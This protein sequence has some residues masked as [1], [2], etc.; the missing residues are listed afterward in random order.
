MA[1]A[2]MLVEAGIKV[3]SWLLGL[4]EESPME[5]HSGISSEYLLPYRL[6]NAER[7]GV[8][9]FSKVIATK[10]R[11]PRNGGRG[12]VKAR[13]IGRQRRTEEYPITAATGIVSEGRNWQYIRN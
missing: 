1:S 6:Q 2:H 3:S 10:G 5:A 8:K 4:R 12:D 11:L 13:S 9:E 7:G